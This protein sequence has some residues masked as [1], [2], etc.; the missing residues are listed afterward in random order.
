MTN[1]EMTFFQTAY[2]SGVAMLL[3]AAILDIRAHAQRRRI[4]WLI[5]RLTGSYNP[6]VS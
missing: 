6:R 5:R 1:I 4:E 3:G 2:A